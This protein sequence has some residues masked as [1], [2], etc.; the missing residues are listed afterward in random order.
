MFHIKAIEI[1]A[2]SLRDAVKNGKNGRE[3]MAL[4]QYVAG[5]VDRDGAIALFKET[6]SGKLD[7]DIDW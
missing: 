2:R 7:V 3:G 4:G 6:I 5:N 1:I